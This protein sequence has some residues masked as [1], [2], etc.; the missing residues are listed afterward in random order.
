MGTASAQEAAWQSATNVPR[1][2]PQKSLP[3]VPTPPPHPT[4][5]LLLGTPTLMKSL[6]MEVNHP[7]NGKP[8]PEHTLLLTSLEAFADLPQPLRRQDPLSR[9][10]N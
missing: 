5:G 7:R 8:W 9:H 3:Q 1:R 2:H 4:M 10:H 6:C